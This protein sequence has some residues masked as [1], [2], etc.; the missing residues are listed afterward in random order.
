[1]LIRCK[2]KN[3]PL[4]IYSLPTLNAIELIQDIQAKYNVTYNYPYVPVITVHSL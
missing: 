3:I 2:D 4:N 1:M